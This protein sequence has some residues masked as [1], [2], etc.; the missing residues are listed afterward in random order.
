MNKKA[1]LALADKLESHSIPGLGFNMGQW[2]G[3]SS[4]DRSGRECGTT[5]CIAGWACELHTRKTNVPRWIITKRGYGVAARKMLDLS[6]TQSVKLFL[7]HPDG[8]T[9]DSVPLW[10]AV[11]VLRLLAETG[12]VD[13]DLAYRKGPQCPQLKIGEPTNE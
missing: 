5:A 12:R 6:S 9:M 7:G 4:V 3:H 11:N 10:C 1:I 8:M 2:Y 13:W